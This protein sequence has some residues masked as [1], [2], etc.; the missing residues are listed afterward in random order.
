MSLGRHTYAKFGYPR[1]AKLAAEHG[2][3]VNF[4]W[5][6][7]LDQSSPERLYVDSVHYSATMAKQIA[8]CIV[9]KMTSANLLG[10]P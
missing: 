10:S 9:A 4:L 7:D 3:G 2:L 1:M 5:C 8:Q 6:A